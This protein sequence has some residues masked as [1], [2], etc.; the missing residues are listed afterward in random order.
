LTAESASISSC[1]ERVLTRY[2][3]L[4][5]NRASFRETARRPEWQSR[6]KSWE[7][8]WQRWYVRARALAGGAKQVFSEEDPKSK[9]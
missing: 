6:L 9:V 7:A 8:R 1:A 2:E 5:K 3:Q 4:R